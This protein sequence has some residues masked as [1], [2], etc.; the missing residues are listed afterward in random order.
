M[1]HREDDP[2]RRSVVG[3]IAGAAAAV[4]LAFAIV[5]Q[6]SVH[7]ATT[8]FS[9]VT[10]TGS[11]VQN[12]SRA[13]SS[14]APGG[15]LTG[16]AAPGDT[17][18]WVVPYQNETGSDASVDLT[19]G[20]TSAGAYVAGSLVLP[21]DRSGGTGSLVPQYRTTGAWT[22][23]TPPA[24]SAPTGIGYR[25]SLMPSGTEQRSPTFPTPTSVGALALTG[26]DGYS[27]V[28]HKRL[29]YTIYHHRTGPVVFCA[30]FDGGICPGWPPGA[31]VQYWS[32]TVGAAIGT[33]TSFP[34]K[35]AIQGATWLVGDR[36]YWL[37]APLDNSSNGMACLDLA[38]TPPVSCGYTALTGQSN[39]NSSWSAQIGGTGMPARNGNRYFAAISGGRAA[40]VCLTSTNAACPGATF[41]DSGVTNEFAFTSA[42]FGDFVF[43]SVGQNNFSTWQTFCFDTRT[44]ALCPGS[45]PRD[46]SAGGSI[47]GVGTPFAP[48]LSPEGQV[49]GVCTIVNGPNSSSNCFDLAGSPTGNA[50]SGT[51]AQYIGGGNG[52]G[53]VLVRGTRVYLSNG[54]QVICRDFA[55]WSGTGAV[56]PC[57]GFA[58]VANSINYTVRETPGIAQDCLVAT[59]DTGQI[60]FFDAMTGAAC[61]ATS[62]VDVRVDPVAS[63]CGSGAASFARWG[64]LTVAGLTAGTYRNVTVTLADQSGATLSGFTEVV[65]PAGGLDLSTIEAGVSSL[66]ATVRVNGVTTPSGVT[67]GAVRIAWQG[68]PPEM[69]FETTVPTMSCDAA[70]STISN[71]A[72]AVTSYGSTSDSPGNST[73]RAS[74]TVTPTASQCG[75]SVAKTSSVQTADPGDRVV[76]TIAVKNTG[77]LAYDSAL[78]SDD[79]TDALKDASFLGDQTASSGSVGY[80][81]PVLSWSGALTG[82]AAATVTYSLRIDDPAAGD[83]TLV[84]TVVSASP[85][86]NCAAG[87]S[88]RACTATVVVAVTELVWRKIDDT[89]AHNILT[90]AE[91]T[92]TRVDGSGAPTGTALT[93]TDCVAASPA[94]CTDAD[95]DPLGGAFRVTDLGVGSYRLTETRAPVGYRL[96]PTPIPVTITAASSTVTLPDVVNRQAP[97]PLIPLTG[98]LGAEHLQLA[99]GGVLVLAVG[100][101]LWSLIRRRR[102]A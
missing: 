38:V 51:S 12:G 2:S 22:S 17:V 23:G 9:T 97:V 1:R 24:G 84:N 55:G 81:A 29:I 5:P 77:T 6:S 86:S 92:L 93:V 31:N 63:Y 79:L 4:L 56:P 14:D 3:W 95:V 65:V 45:W 47:V 102:L 53:D 74:F 75:L 59:G 13:A 72:T 101:A 96:D 60:R 48:L 10:T 37:A 16:T 71:S 36:L 90:G 40:L 52:T 66:T 35:T 49:T 42:A 8:A 18:R 30:R 69:C 11:D 82:G 7:A 98:G 67:G 28:E 58:N 46:S 85:Q 19:D 20:L 39:N 15:A 78:F 61:T 43:A 32:A 62:T 54:N 41:Y 80:S 73:G 33:G 50:Y 25:S 34:G 76:Y 44:S 87:S 57:A 99:G 21:P 100:F 68:A 83:R 91:W 27:V 70:P 64:T 26:G 89:A 88:D 94:A